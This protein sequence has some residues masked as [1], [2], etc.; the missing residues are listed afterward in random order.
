MADKRTHFGRAGEYAAMSEFLLRGYNVAIPSVDV[1]DDV[2]IVDDREGTTRRVQVKSGDRSTVRVDE[3]ATMTVQY[4]L[5]RRRFL[6]IP[7]EDLGDIRDRFVAQDRT[8]K[9]GRR[10]RPDG[11]GARDELTLI[12]TWSHTDAVGWNQSFVDY[13][14]RWPA[15]FRSSTQAQALSR[16]LLLSHRIDEVDLSHVEKYARPPLEPQRPSRATVCSCAGAP[17]S[18]RPPSC[19]ARASRGPSCPRTCRTSTTSPRRSFSRS[20]ASPADSSGCASDSCRGERGGQ[21]RWSSPSP[22]VAD[23]ERVHVARASS[24][25]GSSLAKTLSPLGF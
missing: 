3:P 8:G 4:G 25:C 12:V 5:S 21:A 10:P 18:P 13:M 19:F 20:S 16:E 24:M 7:R 14:D 11:D 17:S 9:S 23:R 15:D 6:L 1:G 2:F 22:A